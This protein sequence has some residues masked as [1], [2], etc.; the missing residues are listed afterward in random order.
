MELAEMNSR[1]F[2]RPKPGSGTEATSSV[3]KVSMSERGNGNRQ[4]GA[5][6]SRCNDNRSFESCRFKNARCYKGQQ[7]GHT[8]LACKS[9]ASGKPGKGKV[10]NFAVGHSADRAKNQDSVRCY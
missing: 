6:C 8:A 2:I 5:K 9:G 4:Q 3:N 7:L 10:Q 1:E